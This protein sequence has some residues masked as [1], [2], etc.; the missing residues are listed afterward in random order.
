MRGESAGIG[1][2]QR[3]REKTEVWVWLWVDSGKAKKRRHGQ[4]GEV[5]REEGDGEREECTVVEGWE[6]VNEARGEW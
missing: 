5:V 2:N 1:R 6:A 4:K 3:E